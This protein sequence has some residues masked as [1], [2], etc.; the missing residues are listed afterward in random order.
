MLDDDFKLPHSEVA[1]RDRI[2]GYLKREGAGI[3]N[4]LM[5]PSLEK[6]L[7]L[8]KA[9]IQTASLVKIFCIVAIREVWQQTEPMEES[10]VGTWE[11]I[12]AMRQQAQQDVRVQAAQLACN[13][14]TH[15][16]GQPFECRQEVERYCTGLDAH[17]ENPVALGLSKLLP[18]CMERLIQLRD[19][20]VVGDTAG[21]D[22]FLKLL[23]KGEGDYDPSSETFSTEVQRLVDSI[24]V[25]IDENKGGD[26]A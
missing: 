19:Q 18:V 1:A 14:H 15:H 2:Y 16:S 4:V 10:P 20:V 6:T 7:D 21:V 11:S 26:D 9:D 25:Q 17:T 8:L 12:D 5:E 3:M 24:Q 23:A 13:M 22:E